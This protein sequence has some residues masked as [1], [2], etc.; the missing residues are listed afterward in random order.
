MGND[1]SFKPHQ[2]LVGEI[3]CTFVLMYVV[4][5]TACNE[6]SGAN[7]ALAPLAIGLAVFLAHMILIPIDGCSIN[8]TRTFGPAVVQS[9]RESKG[10][11]DDMW[12][13]WLGPFLG[14]ALAVLAYK[15]SNMNSDN[16]VKV[17]V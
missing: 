2:A 10:V 3:V 13:F 6:K 14:S 4:L 17:D 11:W 1:A 9:F 15:A 8:P 16:A 5:E 7:R 12:V